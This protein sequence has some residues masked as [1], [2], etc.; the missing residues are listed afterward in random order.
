MI[1]RALALFIACSVGGSALAQTA[2]PAPKPA[3]SK[4]AAKA[5]AASKKKKSEA[6]GKSL[7]A[8]T[9]EAITQAQLDIAA[10]VLTGDAQCEFNQLVSIAPLDGQPGRFKLRFKN[11]SYS[12][13]PAETTTG[14]VRL[15]DKKA[16]VVWLQIPTK[17]MLMN[18]KLGQRMVD[19]CTQVEQ[20]IAVE[21][22][23]A[24][25]AAAS[26]ASAASAAASAPE[27]AASAASAPE[28]AASQPVA[29]EKPA[30][31][32]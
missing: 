15:E 28:P 3:A 13:V 32:P 19:G 20:R 14:A 1:H 16:G 17:S 22:A 12:M 7:A 18:S 2:A 11:L 10:R 8:E 29:P 4:P 6:G 26:A 24:A 23:V 9:V 25:A 27:P 31:A 30:S 5:S 21:A